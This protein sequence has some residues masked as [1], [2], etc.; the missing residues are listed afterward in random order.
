MIDE[1]HSLNES[2]LA[3]I[4]VCLQ[5]PAHRQQEAGIVFC[6][7]AA[8]LMTLFCCYFTT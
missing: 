8:I 1:A 2:S 3:Y 6:S 7:Y 5:C 4:T